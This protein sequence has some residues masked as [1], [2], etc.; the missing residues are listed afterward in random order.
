MTRTNAC[1]CCGA[2]RSPRAL[3]F[4]E[5]FAVAIFG[6]RTA[7]LSRQ[8]FRALALLHAAL[9]RPAYADWL[10]ES[11]GMS[12]GQLRKT[13]QRLR[14]DIAPLGLVVTNSKSGHYLLETS[15][16]QLEQTD[17][18]AAS[19]APRPRFVCA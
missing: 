5:E 11:L 4:D 3:Q 9:P 7:A 15:S 14:A 13:I 8:R 1:P 6:E 17:R 10:A 18:R 19:G 12:R 2:P 16:P